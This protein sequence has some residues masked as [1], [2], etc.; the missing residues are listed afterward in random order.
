MLKG[1]RLSCSEISGRKFFFCDRAS[2]K[3]TY[4]SI[5]AYLSAAVVAEPPMSVA[6]ENITAT[7]AVMTWTAPSSAFDG[8][9]VTVSTNGSTAETQL[10]SSDQTTL[11]LLTL[12]PDT[13]YTVNIATIVGEGTNTVVSS[14]VTLSFRTST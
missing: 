1:R 7:S 2:M 10:I 12:E 5:F 3:L 4:T 11:E 14:P 8:F 13:N 9:L 6:V